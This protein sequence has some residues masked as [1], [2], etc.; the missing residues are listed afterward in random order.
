MAQPTV[1]F[2]FVEDHRPFADTKL[3]SLVTEAHAH[4]QLVLDSAVGD[5]RTTDLS[6]THPT[7]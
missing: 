4:E 7:F 2:P 6:I 1:T 5:N 3:H